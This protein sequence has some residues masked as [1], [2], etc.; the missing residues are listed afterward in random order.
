M[1]DSN[2]TDFASLLPDIT[3]SDDDVEED[4]EDERRDGMTG[5]AAAADGDTAGATE[6]LAQLSL[7]AGE[8]S[9]PQQPVGCGS[10]SGAQQTD[11]RSPDIQPC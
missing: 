3:L 2:T 7:G 10:G 5:A 1:Y 11:C 9:S 6:Q 8:C 4:E